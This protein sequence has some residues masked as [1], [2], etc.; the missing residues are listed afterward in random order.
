M[1]KYKGIVISDIHVGANDLSK[2]RQEYSE[3]FIRYIKEMKQLDFLIVDGDFFD[4]KFYLGDKESIVAHAMIKELIEVCEEKNT[5]IRIV[6]GTESHECNQYDVL[7]ALHMYDKIEVVKYAKEEELLPDLHILYLPEEHLLDKDEYYKKY[8][9]NQ[10]KYDYIF[11]H[12]VI[13]EVMKNE[14]VHI[15][16][17]ERDTSVK[18][19]KVPIFKSSELEYCCKGQV[20]FGHYHINYNIND[21][22]FS[23]G[24]FSRW[25]FGEEGPKGF[26][27]LTCNT[28]K[29]S[30]KQTYIE[31]TMADKYI[32]IAYGY[33]DKVFES[34]EKMQEALNHIDKLVEDNVLDHVRC[35]F[36]IPT[37]AENP[38][39]LMN[40]I[41]ERYKFKDHIKTEITHGYIE[42]RREQQKEKIDAEN[43]KYDFIFDKNLPLEE[44]T[45]RFI[46]IEYN[47]NIPSDTVSMYLYHTLNEILDL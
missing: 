36:N 25:K 7:S 30:Y 19:K 2:L 20:Y 38:E 17:G 34:D 31:N 42:E 18:R 1:P 8:F 24:S 10:K 33:D 3:V 39:Y 22:I 6:Y 15:E 26:Y 23:V 46:S 27:E 35:V 29:G 14:V 37:D 40:Y 13:R 12:G 9:S 44:M 16:E 5:V 11:G 41:K 45:S 32:T 4:H 28:E 47:K 21:K 43:K